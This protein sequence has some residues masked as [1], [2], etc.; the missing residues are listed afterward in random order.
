MEDQL[1]VKYQLLQEYLQNVYKNF[2]K[3]SLEEL[4]TKDPAYFNHIQNAEAELTR[5]NEQ[6]QRASQ[7]KEGQNKPSDDTKKQPQQLTL[8]FAEEVAAVLPAPPKQ[9][10]KQKLHNTTMLTR[11]PPIVEEGY[12]A[13]HSGINWPHYENM[14]KLFAFGFLVKDT[15]TS[16]QEVDKVALSAAIE[17]VGNAHYKK[18]HLSA[19]EIVHR[20]NRTYMR[21]GKNVILAM[22]EPDPLVSERRLKDLRSEI[23]DTRNEDN[24]RQLHKMMSKARSIYMTMQA[25][26]KQK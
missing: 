16:Q 23:F 4:K 2:S 11:L 24:A 9:T 15:L 6:M 25:R 18:K 7:A 21:Y 22:A 8:N 1:S 19:E 17:S 3:E 5:L 10:H 13:P 14:L 20:A 26:Y 12:D